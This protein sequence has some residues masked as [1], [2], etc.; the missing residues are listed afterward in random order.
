MIK[1]YAQAISLALEEEMERDKNL[2]LIGEDVGRYG[3]V[4]KATG[5]FMRN[6]ALKE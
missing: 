6:L 4:F 3:G 2:T 5:G 1:T